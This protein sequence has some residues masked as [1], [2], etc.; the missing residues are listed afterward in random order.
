[1][2]HYDF[3]SQ[4]LWVEQDIAERI[5]IP[6]ERAQANY[7]LNVLRMQEGDEMLIL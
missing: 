5:A 6:C 3:K 4:R 7:L 2:S 1:M